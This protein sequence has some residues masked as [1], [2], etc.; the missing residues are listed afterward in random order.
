MEPHLLFLIQVW[1]FACSALF[2]DDWDS[3]GI[4]S[5]DSIALVLS[6]VYEKLLDSTLFS[7][8]DNSSFF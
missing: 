7:K 1:K 8:I 3:V 2:T 6:L 5:P 4:A